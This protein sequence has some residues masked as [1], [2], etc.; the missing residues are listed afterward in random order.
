M[1]NPEKITKRSARVS[2][3]EDRGSEPIFS[4]Y[5]FSLLWYRRN[6]I[7]AAVSLTLL[8]AALYL[9]FAP[10]RYTATTTIVLETKQSPVVHNE[11][12]IEPQ[13][14]AGAVE[15]QVE[16]IRS[17]NVA[18]AVIRKL[19]LTEDPE[20]RF[21]GI[22]SA[23][24]EWFSSV[25]QEWFS[26]GS[27]DTTAD[28]N[29][30]IMLTAIGNF[31]KGLS[32][33]RIPHSY[34]VEIAFTSLDPKKATT[35][36]NVIAE[37]YIEDERQAKVELTK[38]A[39]VWLQE[40]IAELRSK[41]TGAFESVQNFKSQNN[42]LI[43]SDNKLAWDVELAQLTELLAKARAAT[44]LARSRL[45]E[46][47][48]VISTR[49]N[50]NG[51][52]DPTVADALSSAVITKLRQQYLEDEKYA[53][54]Y[55]SRYGSSH[56]SVIKLRSEMANLNRQIRAE[57]ER[58]A[59]TYKTDLKVAQSDEQAI[60][61]RI[62]GVFQ[63]N[64]GNR[65]AQV[66]LRE[67][68][69]AANTYR[70]V[71][72]DFLN[73]YTQAVQQQLF[74]STAARVITFASI[75]K[76]S[77]PKI[78]LTLALATIGGASLGAAGVFIREQMHRAIY[79]RNQVIRELGVSCIAALPVSERSEK[80]LRSTSL[81]TAPTQPPI[82]TRK[83]TLLGH[84]NNDLPALLVNIEDPFSAASEALRNIKVAMDLRHETRTLG[85][86]SALAN[87]GKSSIALSLAARMAKAGRN[88]LLVD[89]DFRKPSLTNFLGLK[90]RAGILELLAAEAELAD[91][92][93][94]QYD[95]DFLCGPTKIR[96]VDIDDILNS[97]PMAKL[98][99][100][101]KEHYDSVI[102][103]LPPIL[104]MIDIRACAH[105]FDAFALVAEWG[106]T[107][108]D[109]LDMAFRVAPLVHERL[110]GIVLNKVDVAV[111]QRIEGSG[112]AAYG[113]YV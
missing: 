32:V 15:T 5:A 73:R 53:T 40:G 49:S 11:V 57:I 70:S 75:G 100:V 27:A 95:F 1:L 102:V 63:N 16:T 82:D 85:I 69:T 25:L 56:Q 61:K 87:E 13:V 92:T 59:E 3:E 76:R 29:D 108:I 86:V 41:A 48:A 50:D 26:T 113:R 22:V 60:E 89:C 106:K 77:S 4:R 58:I 74:P 47:E 97:G 62:S 66:K 39:R 91:V 37:A 105:L 94:R 104:P 45:A 65:Q 78:L 46:I 112:Y 23:L 2:T 33:T 72:E 80:A 103:D 55:A 51:L 18:A 43:G 38:Q 79:S 31:E 8:V 81:L 7:I 98:L 101:M 52:P 84:K 12:V 99:A 24:E 111:I 30:E 71:Y 9:I 68:E 14:D 19:K 42:L 35:I 44:T 107:S 36:A 34:A 67:L 54:A 110:L 90:N 109:D 17:E 83:W 28:S 10:A 20:F 6:L 93:N 64:S 21:E 96:P 88:V